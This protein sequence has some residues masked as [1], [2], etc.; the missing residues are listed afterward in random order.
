MPPNGF[1]MAGGQKENSTA[2]R[3]VELNMYILY[4]P[5][6]KQGNSVTR[7]EI[8][9]QQ[10]HKLIPLFYILDID[11]HCP[12]LLSGETMHLP[13]NFMF[14]FPISTIW[15]NHLPFNQ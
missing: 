15:W 2:I 10:V 9:R 1:A 6:Y 14:K 12:Y 4:Q 3:L 7:A 5:T 8:S 13:F 11:S